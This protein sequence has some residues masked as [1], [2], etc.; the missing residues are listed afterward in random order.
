MIT[1]SPLVA[2]WIKT[3]KAECL[4]FVKIVDGSG[5]VF[6]AST[7]HYSDFTF[8]DNVTYKA[9]DFIISADPPQQSSTVDREQ[10]KLTVQDDTFGLQAEAENGL[11]G[12]D[13]TVYL[14]FVN[15]DTGLVQATFADTFILYQGIIDGCSG[16]LS[17]EAVGE[18]VYVISG[19]SPMVSLEQSRGFYLS[20]DNVRHRN[21]KDASFDSIYTGSGSL[22]LK[23]GRA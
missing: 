14:G 12:M 20:R 18:A 9:D 6:R 8:Q 1:F 16:T 10:Y 23:W 11:V 3:N 17:T 5:T 4:F 21:A 15:P 7:T 13:M 2:S 19:A 22:I